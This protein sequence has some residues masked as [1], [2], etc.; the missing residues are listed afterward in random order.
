MKN[1]KRI[2]ATLAVMVFTVV[3][4]VLPLG[5]AV[6]ED[7]IDDVPWDVERQNRASQAGEDFSDALRAISGV[8]CV[9]VYPDYYG[10]CYIEDYKL[11]VDFH[12]ISDEDLTFVKQELAEYSDI[13][14]YGTAD[15]SYNEL[16]AA[17]PAFVDA[18]TAQGFVVTMFGVSQKYNGF[19]CGVYSEDLSK[20]ASDKLEAEAMAFAK[21]ITNYPVSILVTDYFRVQT[22][23]ESSVDT[24][25]LTSTGVAP[26]EAA[27]ARSVPVAL[28]IAGSALLVVG[29]VTAAILLARRNRVKQG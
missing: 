20:S 5:A 9:K 18:M 22:K 7:A 6:A 15:Y 16:K 14:V 28:I 27:P 26:A 25:A 17:L 11:Y 3:A 19:T 2:I 21:T 8:D 13:I 4:L 12:N 23:V 1:L 10:C 24:M 29:A